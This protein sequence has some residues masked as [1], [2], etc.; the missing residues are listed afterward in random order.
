MKSE[1]G[2][3]PVSI[4][5]SAPSLALGALHIVALCAFGISQPVF[6][7]TSRGAAFF[8]VRGSRP[9]DILFLV[10]FL[11]VVLPGLL[12]LIE[13]T[14]RY[15]LGRRT[16][17]SFHYAAVSIL[18][19]LYV[20][21]VFRK[22]HNSGGALTLVG[23]GLLAV[24]IAL[25]YWRLGFVRQFLT[26]V[27]VAALAFP[28]LFVF[29]SP[30]R[31]LVF[32]NPD[33]AGVSGTS[34]RLEERPP[35]FFIVLDELPVTSLLDGTGR[36]DAQRFPNL[37]AFADTANWFTNAMTVSADTSTSVPAL[38]SGLQ[39]T[40]KK[41]PTVTEY[42][43]NLFTLFRDTY[44]MNVFEEATLLCPPSLVSTR[45]NTDGFNRRMASMFEDLAV[46]Y[47]HLITP[48]HFAAALPAINQGW[49]GFLDEETSAGLSNGESVIGARG[50][51]EDGLASPSELAERAHE[52][53]WGDR[54]LRFQEFMDS[55]RAGP[56]T[57]IN[58]FHWLMPHR[59]W[60]YLPNGK[61]YWTRR[62][63]DGVEQTGEDW[64]GPQ[65]LV[66]QFHSRHLLQ[67]AYV[68]KRLGDFFDRLVK[69][70]VFDDAFIVI[71]AD[72]GA[73]FSAGDKWRELTQTN[74]GEIV[75]VPLLLKTPGQTKGAVFAGFARTTDILP[76]IAG[77]LGADLPWSADG[78]NLLSQSAETPE[79]VGITDFK[80]KTWRFL[81][82]K[83]LDEKARVHRRN[84]ELF[85]LERKKRSLY[86]VGSYLELLGK[87]PQAYKVVDGDFQFEFE[88]EPLFAD[89]DP[90]GRFIPASVTG[91]LK[92]QDQ[93]EGHERAAI[94]VNGRIAGLG[95]VYRFGDAVRFSGLVAD[96]AYRAGSNRVRL[97]LIGEGPGGEITLTEAEQSDR[98]SHINRVSIDPFTGFV[99]GEG[100]QRYSIAQMG[101]VRGKVED[102][103]TQDEVVTLIGWAA[104]FSNRRP[105]DR[106]AVFEGKRTLA[107]TDS[108]IER[109]HV[110]QYLG[111]SQDTAFGCSLVLPTRRVAEL[112]ETP[113][114]FAL[115]ETRGTAT[116]LRFT[117]A[118]LE[119]LRRIAGGRG[120]DHGELFRLSGTTLTRVD[121]DSV[122]LRRGA[123]SGSIDV[124]QR[125]VSGFTFFGWAAD[126]KR[127]R[128]AAA[129][130]CFVDGQFSGS[131]LPA[132]SR[133]DVARSF[134]NPA[135]GQTGFSF[136]LSADFFRDREAPR[137]RFIA[138][139]EDG[140]A[141]ELRYPEG[142]EW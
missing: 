43:N 121:G 65:F 105:L 126:I 77:V 56:R 55:L 8:V 40:D 138:V 13:I 90:A 14:I 134:E 136:T 91:H 74:V 69:L 22:L 140:N 36:I 12:I 68:D 9:L 133:P 5:P 125:T 75:F 110:A 137:I 44:S 87:D 47:L 29:A 123:V 104:D 95:D 6:E 63:I 120:L 32:S 108:F 62:K 78:S 33:E 85:G 3:S 71:V 116:Q 2:I 73:C 48:A 58:F 115:S 100:G 38:L 141:S 30:V 132:L 82:R 130:L 131:R 57:S 101:Q 76:T 109:V 34:I 1:R 102:I 92:L 118:T 52:S 61:Q 37:A 28:I 119:K 42:P 70:G 107:S 117:E 50:A 24:V 106:V 142:Y 89:V 99:V 64:I 39:P 112:K 16:Q 60:V 122:E 19:F 86:G 26:L 21:Q 20:L 35:I 135:L 88:Q 66:D 51:G 41:V 97:F 113:L 124:A 98:D 114:F 11:A 23:A 111:V 67:L 15:T 53:L 128:G 45:R 79:D 31:Q 139:A 72:H 59:P 7:I 46:V 103:V 54:D 18:V 27:S 93:F 25:A 84:V 129:V 17:L 4:D 80:G 49:G 83:L 94:S 10:G 96:H 81:Y 127:S